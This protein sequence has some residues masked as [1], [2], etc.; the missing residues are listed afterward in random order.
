MIYKRCVRCGKRIPSGTTCSCYDKVKDKRVYA[1]ATGIKAEYH[2][3]RWKDMRA[4]IMSLYNG[5]DIYMMYKHGRM[6]PAD[7]VHH[8]QRTADRPDLFYSDSNLIP[9]SDVA[10]KEI[11]HRYKTEDTAAVQEELKEYMRRYKDTGVGRKVFDDF[12][13]PLMPPILPQN[14]KYHDSLHN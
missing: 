9:V 6:I 1:K 5:I 12:L 2:T 14:S 4:Y 10:H 3:Q 8:I 13:R 11:H 7:T